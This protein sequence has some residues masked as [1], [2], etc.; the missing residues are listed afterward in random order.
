MLSVCCACR[1]HELPMR[2]IVRR[3]FAAGTG[4]GGSEPASKRHRPAA[5]AAGGGGSCYLPQVTI[6][7]AA[8]SGLPVVLPELAAD[9]APTPGFVGGPVTMANLWL[10]SVP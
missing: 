3:V 8:G 10:R 2:E 9:I 1:Q 4:A 7:A 5:T 6:A